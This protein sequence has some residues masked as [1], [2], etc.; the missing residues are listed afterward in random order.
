MEQIPQ[1]S[2]NPHP[3]AGCDDCWRIVGTSTK[4]NAQPSVCAKCVEDQREEMWNAL[5][6]RMG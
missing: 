4:A 1:F 2:F 6:E 3:V 5:N